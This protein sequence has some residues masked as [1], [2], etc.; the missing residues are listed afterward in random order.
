MYCKYSIA[1]SDCKTKVPHLRLLVQFDNCGSEISKVPVISCPVHQQETVLQSK[2]ASVSNASYQRATPSPVSGARSQ[3]AAISP[4]PVSD[5]SSQRAATSPASV[6]DAR[7]QRAAASPAASVPDSAARRSAASPAFIMDN[8]SQRSATSVNSELDPLAPSPCTRSRV[9]HWI[10]NLGIGGIFAVLRT[11]MF[12]PDHS[13]FHP[14]IP[15]PNSFHPG[16][17]I[18]IKK[19]KYFNPQK[20]VSKHSEI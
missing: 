15:D 20:N 4:A 19:F 9:A 13:F 8:A 14:W 16:S 17:R 6:S 7:S 2:P 10:D 11:R 1:F 5:A 12:I 3:R 18:R